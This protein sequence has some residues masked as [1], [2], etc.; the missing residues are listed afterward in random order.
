MDFLRSTVLHLCIL[1]GEIKCI[2][3]LTHN[4]LLCKN[5]NSY[6]LVSMCVYNAVFFKI[7]IVVY[8]AVFLKI[9]IGIF[10]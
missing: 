5:N 3:D 6:L 4:S 10:I 8:N 9:V 2:P 1:C 7:V